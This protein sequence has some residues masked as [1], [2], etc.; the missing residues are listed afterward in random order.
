MTFHL[1]RRRL[2]QIGVAATALCGVGLRASAGTSLEVT[3]AE[4]PVI[5]VERPASVAF[6]G[7]PFAAPPVGD[8]RFRA[9]QSALPRDQPLHVTDYAAAPIQKQPR[10]G[11]YMDGPMPVSEDCLYLNIWRPKEPGPHPVYVWIHGGGNVA[12]A[13]RMPV[14]DGDRL[15]RH[16]IVC[17]TI[18]YRVGV[19]GFLDVSSIL[20]DDYR[21]SGNNGLLDI[22]QALTWVRENIAAFGGDPEAVTVSGQSAGGKN[23]CSLL[24]FPAAKGLFRAAICESGG[25]ETAM[26]AERAH[27]MASQFMDAA[28]GLDIK[29]AT[30]DQL[31]DAQNRFSPGWDRKYPFRAIVDGVHMP[32]V[33]LYAMRDGESLDVPVLMGTTRDENAFFGPN[34]DNSGTVTQSALANMDID[35]FGDIYAH[36]DTALPDASPTERRYAAL[37]AEEYWIPTLRAAEMLTA[38]GRRAYVY[39]L[40]MPRD[41]AP[42]EGY[43]VHGS[44]LPLVWSKLD[45]PRSAELG[46]EGADAEKLSA[47]MHSDWV[48]FIK[49]GQLREDWPAYG[50]DRA[51]MIYDADARIVKDPDAA[52]RK[53]WSDEAFDFPL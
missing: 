19:F 6:Y 51:T 24:T 41:E 21:G 22:V 34:E 45:D 13:S 8:L 12:G 50:A 53:L 28:E 47:L 23:V 43:A 32:K 44:E 29:T 2:L 49:T 18:S 36:Y 15:A 11:L 38:S 10:P 31:L 27:E 46:P 52:Q 20:G 1:N 3:T 42:N 5:G 25:A 40:D 14:F 39:R 7:I 17:V 33:P 4:G 48:G 16:G 35:T 30:A 26:S 9:P 37:T